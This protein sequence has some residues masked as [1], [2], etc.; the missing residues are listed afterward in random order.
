MSVYFLF[1]FF[2]FSFFFS[3][4]HCALHCIVELCK[5][6][7]SS[8][9]VLAVAAACN[10]IPNARLEILCFPIF[11]FNLKVWKCYAFCIF[12]TTESQQTFLYT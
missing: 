3:S 5:K 8:T 9:L 2:V 4:V 10:Q 6:K 12:K 11:C 1:L 7:S